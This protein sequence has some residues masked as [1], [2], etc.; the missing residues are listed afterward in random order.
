MLVT[1][2]TDVDIADLRQSRWVIVGGVYP[3]PSTGRGG[4]LGGDKLMA[5]LYSAEFSKE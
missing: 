3:V 5:T 4:M 2:Y 1:P